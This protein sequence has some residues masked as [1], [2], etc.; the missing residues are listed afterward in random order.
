MVLAALNLF[1]NMKFSAELLDFE[2]NFFIIR[3]A[4]ASLGVKLSSMMSLI[5]FMKT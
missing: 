4:S 5:F 1:D 3:G 2:Y